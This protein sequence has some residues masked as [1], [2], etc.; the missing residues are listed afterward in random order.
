MQAL[1]EQCKPYCS[2]SEC[3]SENCIRVAATSGLTT[4][5]APQRSPEVR[6]GGLWQNP[7]AACCCC[8][9]T[10]CTSFLHRTTNSVTPAMCPRMVGSPKR[11]TQGVT[12][13]ASEAKLQKAN[14]SLPPILL[15]LT[16]PF[17]SEVR[18]RN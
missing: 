4:R 18:T 16:L 10:N 17:P 3:R 13:G 5:N 15:C 2:S 11:I 9:D 8:F 7:C 12:F 6:R 14:L 1:R